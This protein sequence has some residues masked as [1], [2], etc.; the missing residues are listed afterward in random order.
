MTSNKE[1]VEKVARQR[2]IAVQCDPD[3]NDVK[4]R[5]MWADSDWKNWMHFTIE[6][7]DTFNAIKEAGFAVV[8]VEQIA[9]ETE[10][11]VK[12]FHCACVYDH[13]TAEQLQCCEGH[14]IPEG[15]IKEN[16]LTNLADNI[17]ELDPE[18]AE[19]IENNFFDLTTPPE[20][21]E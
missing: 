1:L 12:G 15:E 16:K 13:H 5:S 3:R 10:D 4:F 18:F 2:C 14:R 6:I 9:T 11:G 8:P 7:E 21:S 17:Q 20:G 19:V